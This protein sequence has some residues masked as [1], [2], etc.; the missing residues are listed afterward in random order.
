MA[1]QTSFLREDII[2]KMIGV[3][4][5]KGYEGATVQDLV[6]A[7]GLHPGSLYNSFGNKQAIFRAAI[8]R[9]DATSPFNLLLAQAETAPPGEAIRRLLGGVVDPEAEEHKVAGCLITYASAEVGAADTALADRLNQSFQ[10]MEDRLCRLIERGQ[11]C[12]DFASRR[13]PRDLA[14]FLLST[15][16]GIQVMAKVLEDRSRLQVAADIAYQTLEPAS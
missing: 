4:M 5:T 12:G 15:V 2:D 16:Q 13:N 14:R 9:F 7:T 10:L 8:D 3:F 1:R 11:A 6:D